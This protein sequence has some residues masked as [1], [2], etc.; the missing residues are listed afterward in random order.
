MAIQAQMCTDNIGFP[1]CGSQDLVDNG[2]GCV[3]SGFNQFVYNLQ[4]QQLQQE[5]MQQQQRNQSLCFGNGVLVVPN[6]KNNNNN[7]SMAYPLMD[8]VEKQRQEINQYIRSQNDR[9]RVVLQEQ[10]R[11][12]LA[13][14]VKKIESRTSILLR[15]KDE[16]IVQATKRAMELEIFLKRLEMENQT[17]QRVAQ[18]NEAM[19]VSL[20]NTLDQLRERA[21]SCCFNNEAEDVESCCDMNSEEE[22]EK[23]R[24]F[25]VNDDNIEAERQNSVMMCRVCNT[26]NAC[27]LLLPCRHLC[28]CKACE[29]FLESCPICG[30]AKKASIEVLIS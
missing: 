24:G 10:R 2:F 1:L 22:T 20:N 11:Q 21:S 13:L 27:V 12:Q 29:A 30:I 9:L 3:N 25:C 17:W 28:S 6:S 15:Q 18:E 4:Q 26:R 7:S 19:V 23:N 16:E 8:Q 14:L 5:Y